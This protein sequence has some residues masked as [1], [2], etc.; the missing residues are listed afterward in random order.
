MTGRRGRLDLAVHPF[1]VG[2]GSDAPHHH[3]RG[4][5][6][7]RSTA[8]IPPST[9]SAI[10]ATSWTSTPIT[11]CRPLGHGVS[12]GVH[13][14]QSRIYENQIG[15]SRA[16]TGWMFGQMQERFGDFG[17]GLGAGLLRRGQPGAAGL[18][19]HRGRR[20]ALQPAHHDALRSGAGADPGR[21]GG[22]RSGSR[23]ERPFPCRFRRGGGPARRMGCCRM[24]IGRWGCS[25]ISRPIRWAMSMPAA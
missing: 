5:N 9:R 20:G 15:R 16:F 1:S 14:S 23:V 17:V 4:R 2:G 21:S 18:H 25:A 10:P 7:S 11:R 19:P 12:M 13:E 24:C 3:P 8:S 6:A 22:G